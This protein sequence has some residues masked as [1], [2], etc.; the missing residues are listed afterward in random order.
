MEVDGIPVTQFIS[1]PPAAYFDRLD[2]TVDALGRAI[3]NL[4]DDCVQ[5]AP[6]VLFYRSGHFFNRLQSAPNGPG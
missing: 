2:S 3:I 1:K 6:E 4:Q 5:N